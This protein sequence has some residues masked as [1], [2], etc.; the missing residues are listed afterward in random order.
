MFI[1]IERPLRPDLPHMCVWYA[2]V[3]FC[4]VRYH[5]AP[6]VVQSQNLFTLKV[7]TSEISI[8][9]SRLRFSAVPQNPVSP[10]AVPGP[11]PD[12]PGRGVPGPWRALERGFDPSFASLEPS[13]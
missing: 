10:P 2:F 9:G 8:A 7:C 3:V 6:S 4:T 13:S 11:P 1:A 5:F 12:P